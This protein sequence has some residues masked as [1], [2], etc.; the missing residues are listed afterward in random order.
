MPD[1]SELKKQLEETQ[2]KAEGYN[3]MIDIAEKQ[4]NIPIRKKPG[5]K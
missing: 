1:F 4:F 2:I 5:T 3:L